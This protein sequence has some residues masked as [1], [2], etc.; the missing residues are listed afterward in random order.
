LTHLRH[1]PA[2]RLRR[3]ATFHQQDFNALDPPAVE[4]LRTI[5][6]G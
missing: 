3:L 2:A 4:R 6:K 5:I 1:V